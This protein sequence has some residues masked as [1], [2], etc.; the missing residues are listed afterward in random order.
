MIF[1]V[2]A[3]GQLDTYVR[4]KNQSYLL[5]CIISNNSRWKINANIKGEKRNLTQ[6]IIGDL[7]MT[8]W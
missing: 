1:S 3:M 7:S 2:M 4:K 5:F 6:E 8:L